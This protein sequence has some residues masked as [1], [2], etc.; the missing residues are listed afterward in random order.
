MSIVTPVLNGE[1]TIGALVRALA[2][3]Q[4]AKSGRFTELGH[5]ILIVDNGS[6]DGTRAIVEGAAIP[7]LRVLH[8]ARR[9]PSAARNR[10]L[11]EARGR[12]IAFLDADSVPTRSWLREMVEAFDDPDVLIVAGGLASFPPRTG[13]QRFAAGYGINDATRMVQMPKLPFANTRNM[14][15]F[16]YAALAVDGFPEEMIAGEDVEF[17][18]RVRQR[19]G[20]PITF[21]PSALVFHQ[22]RDNDESLRAQAIG[23][24]RSMAVLYARHPDLLRWGPM[25]RVRRLRSQTGRRLSARAHD[26]AIRL[27]R[28]DAASHEFARYL[29]S[30][31]QW[32]WS[33]FDEERRSTRAAR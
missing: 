33:G 9:G 10:G 22:D 14:A 23:Y 20:S 19:F 8:E 24:G 7:S 1:R 27:G 21:R 6:T 13:A 18:Y 25:E 4:P 2:G 15:I 16:R 11:R 30:W 29:A 12:L 31:T 3:Q 32:F 26:V 17:S 28:S 5:E